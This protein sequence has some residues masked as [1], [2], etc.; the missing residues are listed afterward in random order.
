LRSSNA[1]VRTEQEVHGHSLLIHSTIEVVPFASNADVSF[2]N[3]PRRAYTA[4]IAMPPLPE[5]GYVPDHPAQYR[6]V[7]HFD[8]P[9]GHDGNEISVA[10]PVRDEPANAEFDDL[11][12]NDTAA[13]NG[14]TVGRFGHLGLV[15]IVRIV[16]GCPQ[17]HQN[18]PDDLI[19]RGCV[20]AAEG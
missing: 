11:S 17:M 19:A 9:L 5:L 20:N 4:R 2:V 14:V 6:R 8:A 1:S 16:D 12:I 7:R 15:G 18:P 3:P 10:Q 13:V